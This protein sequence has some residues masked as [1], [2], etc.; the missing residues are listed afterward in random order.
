[1]LWFFSVNY[2]INSAVQPLGSP[3]KAFCSRTT[4][5]GNNQPIGFSQKLPL[6][7]RHP[8]R[9]TSNHGPLT[10]Y[11]K[12]RVA[13]APGMPGTF[14]P[15]PRVS[16]PDMQ[17]GTCVT[18]VPWC[19]PGSLTSGFVWSRWWRKRSRR[20]RNLQFYVSGKRPMM[21][22]NGPLMVILSS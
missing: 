18:H 20:M 9:Y 8:I 2:V 21:C 22:P 3:P 11:V 5:L 17:H 14:S 13:H 12:L 1:M 15:P 16:D 7:E 6:S 4:P 10:R 19:M